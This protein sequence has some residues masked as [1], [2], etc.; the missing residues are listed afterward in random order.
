[1]FKSFIKVKIAKLKCFLYFKN[2][3]TTGNRNKKK[4]EIVK[5]T[6]MVFFFNG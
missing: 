3:K 4:L 2:V 1:M 6:Q 5:L